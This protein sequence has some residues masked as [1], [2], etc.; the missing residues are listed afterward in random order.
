M[1]IDCV[2]I[3]SFLKFTL[4]MAKWNPLAREWTSQEGTQLRME[5]LQ[6]FSPSKGE[7]NWTRPPGMSWPET[8]PNKCYMFEW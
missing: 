5:F 2:Q 6:T 7:G 8:S 4:Q 3:K 1:S